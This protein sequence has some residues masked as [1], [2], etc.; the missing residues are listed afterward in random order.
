MIVMDEGSGRCFA[1]WK[2]LMF[3][4]MRRRISVAKSYIGG[5]RSGF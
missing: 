1:S 5:E 2:W 3:R 4:L